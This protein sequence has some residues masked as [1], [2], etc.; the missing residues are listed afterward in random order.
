MDLDTTTPLAA[1]TLDEHPITSSLPTLS[2]SLHTMVPETL[3]SLA[4][5][6]SNTPR[7]SASLVKSESPARP[8][9]TTAPTADPRE[10]KLV[11]ESTNDDEQSEYVH[12]VIDPNVPVY[13]LTHGVPDCLALK[14]ID[15]TR[16]A[17]GTFPFY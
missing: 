1:S 17:R 6:P 12:H 11:K 10:P 5:R 8:A 16:Y 4:S 3:P 2:S 13:E 14:C 15:C 7:N 9:L